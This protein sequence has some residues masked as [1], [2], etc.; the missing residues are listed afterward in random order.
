MTKVSNI[1][2][3]FETVN[4]QNDIPQSSSKSDAE[5]PTPNIFSHR[6]RYFILIL[7]C[8]C[9]T[10]ICSNLTALNFTFI[11]ML[12]PSNGNSTFL[13]S[14]STVD[15]PTS[16]PLEYYYNQ[17]EKSM[18]MW[19]AAVGSI[20][21]TFPYNYLYTYFGARYVFFSAG[22]ISSVS[23]LL[24]PAAA[25]AGLIWFLILR[26]FQGIAYAAD[27]AAIGI[28]CSRW[29]A[30]KQNGFFVAILTCFTQISSTITNPVAGIVS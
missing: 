18:L 6:F 3:A 19:A 8:S 1:S 26:L 20:V 12:K 30:L 17:N 24:V 23:T 25:K 15:A 10:S 29:A 27:F 14:N 28:L 5:I 4:L 16:P 22:I 9:L 11:C 21:A 13:F 2:P 7:G